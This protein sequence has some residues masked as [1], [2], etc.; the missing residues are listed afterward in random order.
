MYLQ[1]RLDESTIEIISVTPN[2]EVLRKYKEGVFKRNG[3]SRLGNITASMGVKDRITTFLYSDRVTRYTIDDRIDH[4]PL[5]SDS[6]IRFRDEEVSMDNPV[7][8]NYLNGSYQKWDP[9]L[10]AAGKCY[11]NSKAYPETAYYPTE[12]RQI[13]SL[14]YNRTAKLKNII[15]LPKSLYTLQLFESGKFD[16][17][18]KK[19]LR[20]LAELFEFESIRTL[21]LNELEE[22]MNYGVI[23]NSILSVN[24]KIDTQTDILKRILK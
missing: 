16:K 15:E 5:D 2:V 4:G 7:I 18:T 23:S 21:D 10:V 1:K 13:D 20:K 14:Y 17:I 9:T 24:E 11:W 12:D 19:N 6:W 8:E 3:G 22:F